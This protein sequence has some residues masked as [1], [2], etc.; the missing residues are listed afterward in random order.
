MSLSEI[1]DLYTKCHY[2]QFRAENWSVSNWCCT[3]VSCLHD[4]ICAHSTHGHATMAVPDS[5]EDSLPT[6][7]KLAG[8]KRGIT[9][10]KHKKYL[11]QASSQ[12]C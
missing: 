11:A 4:C 5:I 6:V 3:Y 9:E 2:V 10:P 12:G 7:C 1:L 8:H